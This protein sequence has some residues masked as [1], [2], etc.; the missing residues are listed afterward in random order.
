M[1]TDREAKLLR[2]GLR[3]KAIDHAIF[4]AHRS[5][6]LLNRDSPHEKVCCCDWTI[7]EYGLTFCGR[8]RDQILIFITDKIGFLIVLGNESTLVITI[9]HE[10]RMVKHVI[11]TEKCAHG[12]FKKILLNEIE[13]LEVSFRTDS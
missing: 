5:C 1:D 8:G 10:D 13:R 3:S 4:L 7:H 9:E 2:K 11:K 12:D 6:F